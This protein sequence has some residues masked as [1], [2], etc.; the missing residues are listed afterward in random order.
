M[1]ET[2]GKENSASATVLRRVVDRVLTLYPAE[3]Y[4]LILWSH[5]MGG[6]RPG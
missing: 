2:Y 6:F 1:I 4:G 5:G 3:S